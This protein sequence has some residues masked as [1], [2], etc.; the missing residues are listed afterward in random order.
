MAK[1]V[2][3]LLHADLGIDIQEIRTWG[4]WRSFLALIC[5]AHLHTCQG[6]H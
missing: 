3:N 1:S 4:F 2:T 6:A 5:H